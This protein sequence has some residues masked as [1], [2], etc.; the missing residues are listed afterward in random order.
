MSDSNLR[1]TT[2]QKREGTQASMDQPP[3][4]LVTKDMKRMVENKLK[5]ANFDTSK[6]QMDPV[7]RRMSTHEV[8]NLNIK[9]SMSKIMKRK[10][11]LDQRYQQLMNVKQSNLSLL[12]MIKQSTIDDKMN[13]DGL[14]DNFLKSMNNNQLNTE[15][16]DL[17][18]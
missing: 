9:D 2:L 14:F 7:I 5:D 8:T 11:I 13:Y 17:I 1:P 15:N 6:G 10:A 3:L 16:A 4:F 18:Q 12:E